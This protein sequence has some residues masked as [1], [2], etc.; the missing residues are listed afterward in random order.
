MTNSNDQPSRTTDTLRQRAAYALATIRRHQQDDKRKK[1]EYATRVR[2]LGP[3]VLQNGLGQALAF[4]LADAKGERAHAAA[5]L[6]NELQEWLAGGRTRE[7]PERVYDGADLIAG[8]ITGSRDQYQRAQWVTL[9]LLT[10]MKKFTDAFLAEEDK[11]P[12]AG[13]GGDGTPAEVRP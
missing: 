8:L 9:D 11:Q 5:R 10:W 13:G 1:A 3:M 12:S 2:G 7:R 4:L 6:Y